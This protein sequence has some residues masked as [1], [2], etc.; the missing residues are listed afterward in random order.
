MADNQHK[1]GEM[2]TKAQEETFNGFMRWTVN[3]ALICIGVVV[4]LAL[5]A[6]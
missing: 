2:D 1:H 3:V 5:F 4:F 6:R